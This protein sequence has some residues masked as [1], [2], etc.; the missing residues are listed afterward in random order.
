MNNADPPVDKPIKVTKDDCITR[1]KVITLSLTHNSTCTAADLRRAMG[2]SWTS[3]N[4]HNSSGMAPLIMDVITALL[5]GKAV[6]CWPTVSYG[7]CSKDASKLGVPAVTRE[8]A[9]EDKAQF[10]DFSDKVKNL[11]VIIVDDNTGEELMNKR[12]YN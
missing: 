3:V 10:H 7:C 8:M 6:G 9:T 11:R 2:H 4:T 1:Q 12:V 5:P